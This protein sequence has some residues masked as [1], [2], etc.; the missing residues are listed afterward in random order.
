MSLLHATPGFADDDDLD[1]LCLLTGHS[2]SLH[3]GRSKR[4]FDFRCIRHVV[5][6]SQCLLWEPQATPTDERWSA[7]GFARLPATF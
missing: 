2:M 1:P 5:D 7:F 3:H 6:T 4:E